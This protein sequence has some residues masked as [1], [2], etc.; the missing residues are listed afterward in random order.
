MSYFIH[1][2]NTSRQGA[3]NPNSLLLGLKATPTGVIVT[4]K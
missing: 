3:F 2:K 1:K 4:K